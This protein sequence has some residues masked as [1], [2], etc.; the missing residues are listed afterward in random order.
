M[1]MAMKVAIAWGVSEL[2]LAI[3]RRSSSS[4]SERKDGSS[5]L[6]L[7]VA[8]GAG[9]FM[10]IVA[11]HVPSAAMPL[12]PSILGAI[13]IMLIVLGLALRIAAVLTLRRFFTVD[14][15]IH[16]GHT[17]VD[18][19]LYRYV[20]HPAYAGVLLSFL[21]FG[22]GLGN[23]LSVAAMFVPV[24]LAITYRIRVEE[25]ALIAALGDAYVQY[26]ARTKRLIPGVL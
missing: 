8:I 24:A 14:V 16:E 15:A 18:H 1:S 9:I 6:L 12:A 10:A 25:R 23:W 20:R 21:G 17:V 2:I 4:S 13:A 3:V 11:T 26:A 5:L 7:W 22:V 19:G